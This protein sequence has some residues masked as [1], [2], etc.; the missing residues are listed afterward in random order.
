[1]NNFP[2]S[3]FVSTYISQRLVFLYFNL[4]L[5]K[6]IFSNCGLHSNYGWQLQHSAGKP[7]TMRPPR[8]CVYVEDN[9]KLDL[10]EIECEGI[11]VNAEVNLQVP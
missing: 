8:T 10:K 1:M 3:C 5:Y 4:F 2:V 7:G 11:F 9:I 6:I